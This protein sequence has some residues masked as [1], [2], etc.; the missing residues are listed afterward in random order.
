M[1]TLAGWLF[2]SG[3]GVLFLWGFWMGYR[4]IA[5]DHKAWLSFGHAP[6][7]SGTF[8]ARYAGHKTPRVA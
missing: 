6:G 8:D 7:G 4:G 5:A 2:I 1:G 3:T